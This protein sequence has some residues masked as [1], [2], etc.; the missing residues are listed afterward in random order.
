MKRLRDQSADRRLVALAL[1][2]NQPDLLEAERIDLLRQQ[3][4]LRELKRQPLAPL[5]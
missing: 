2:I 5:G 4:A 3:Q 1:R